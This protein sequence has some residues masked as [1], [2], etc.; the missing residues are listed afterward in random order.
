MGVSAPAQPLSFARSRRKRSQ[1]KAFFSV[2]RF[3]GY[4]CGVNAVFELN[5]ILPFSGWENAGGGLPLSAVFWI[6][7][8]PPV[9][10]PSG[11]A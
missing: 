2:R 11:K 6:D 9:Q 3:P 10:I 5:H 7:D 8:I 4:C 1:P